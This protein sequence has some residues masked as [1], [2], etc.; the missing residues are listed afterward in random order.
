MEWGV[1]RER[2]KVE[3]EKL[4]GESKRGLQCS[5]GI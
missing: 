5:L 1:E 4:K 2:L 3:R